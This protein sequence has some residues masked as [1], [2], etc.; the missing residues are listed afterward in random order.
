MEAATVPDVAVI[1]EVPADTA[2]ISPVL[3]MVATLA[4]PEV[5]VT[6]LVTS[7]VVPSDS[8]ASA[9]I[10]SVC[11]VTSVGFAG[12]IEIAVTIRLLTVSVVLPVTPPEVAEIVVVPV[13]TEVARPALSMVATLVLEEL[14]VDCEDTLL[15]VPSPSVAVAVN[16]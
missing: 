15:V 14:H 16:C 2:V 5:H 1:V 7:R 9:V 12:A 3:E 13:V 4:L 11:P 8:V 6:V 10:C